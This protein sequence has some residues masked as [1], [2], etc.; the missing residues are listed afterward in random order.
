MAAL[1]NT[2]HWEI[3]LG[4][5]IGPTD[6]PRLSSYRP[7]ILRNCAIFG[8]TGSTCPDHAID[9]GSASEYRGK[10]YAHTPT[11]DNRDGTS[12]DSPF[13]FSGGACSGPPPPNANL[14]R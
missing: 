12:T 3:S 9:T 4:P 5:A 6:L 14:S 2:R 13:R 10:H 8:R 1:L 11:R 7:S